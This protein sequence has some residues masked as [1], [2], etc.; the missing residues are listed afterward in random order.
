MLSAGLMGIISKIAAG[1]LVDVRTHPLEDFLRLGAGGM[2]R[3]P[4]FD[5]TY[6][7]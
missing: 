6:Q 2:L 3:L 7:S 1:A 5:G 4:L